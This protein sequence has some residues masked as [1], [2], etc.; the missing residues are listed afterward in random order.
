MFPFR[1]PGPDLFDF[2]AQRSAKLEESVAAGLV[3]H[4][5]T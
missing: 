4:L 2:L 1:L 3:K 5:G